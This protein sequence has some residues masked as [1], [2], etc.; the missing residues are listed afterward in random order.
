MGGVGSTTAEIY[1]GAKSRRERD[2]SIP[3]SHP[4]PVS[5]K[6]NITHYYRMSQ[7]EETTTIFALAKYANMGGERPKSCISF[8]FV[9]HAVYQKKQLFKGRGRR[10][11]ATKIIRVARSEKKR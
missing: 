2:H 8:L 9:R 7:Q 10:I 1:C 5:K 3:P 4:P 11:Y 6:I